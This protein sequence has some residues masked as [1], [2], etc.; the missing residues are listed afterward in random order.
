M[1]K[2]ENHWCFDSTLTTMEISYVSFAFESNSTLI[3]LFP[4]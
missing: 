2:V 4:A 3:H 1:K